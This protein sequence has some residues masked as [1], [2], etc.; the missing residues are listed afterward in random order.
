MIQQLASLIRDGK[1]NGLVLKIT[2]VNDKPVVQLTGETQGVSHGVFGEGNDVARNAV[3]AIRQALATPVIFRGDDIEASI[4]ESVPLLRNSNANALDTLDG[5]NVAA[6]LDS[7]VAKAEKVAEK[8]KA[9]PAAK[10]ESKAGAVKPEAVK[11]KPVATG[12]AP[13]PKAKEAE[14]VPAMESNQFNFDSL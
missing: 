12:G 5:L 3:V 10:T 14:P 8:S 2:L 11:A 4:I 13:A 7:A 9:A 1:L 6:K